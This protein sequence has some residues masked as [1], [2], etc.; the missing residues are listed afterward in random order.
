MSE[1]KFRIIFY[2][3]FVLFLL[4]IL[5]LKGEI[6]Y[7][8]Y[9]TESMFL[10]DGKLGV[11][12]PWGGALVKSGLPEELNKEVVTHEKCH[13]KQAEKHGIGFLFEY[14]NN[15]DKFENECYR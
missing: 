15:K 10:R 9:V 2:T 11:T 7:S 4:F 5:P 12:F 1:L 13:V 3:S 8:N 14:V 6:R